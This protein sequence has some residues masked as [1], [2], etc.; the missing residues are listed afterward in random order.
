M[1]SYFIIVTCRNSENSIE[2]ALISL[3]NQS[4]KPEYVIVVDDGSTD[5]TP[6]ILM[7]IKAEWS[8]SALHIITNP[9]LGYNIAR[10]VSN[11]NNAI[12]YM[13]EMK[14]KATDYHMI[15]TDDTVY[16]EQYAEKLVRYMGEDQAIA[17][18]SGDYGEGMA[19]TPHG[20]GRVVRNSFFFQKYGLYPEKMGYESVVLYAAALHNYTYRVFFDARFEH[21][22]KLGTNHHFYEFGASM[23]SLG[24][25]PLFVLGRF[26]IYFIS[27]KPIGRIGALYML[28]HYLHFKPKKD[29]YGSLHDYYIRDFIRQT[30]RNRI[31]QFLKF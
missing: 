3:R 9:D 16:E 23:R 1:S 14:L 30:Q 2:Q 27:G 8:G 24:Y 10:V 25:H 19:K 31:K 5:K 13:H 17:I 18:S 29:G 21:L 4:L 6:E 15:T 22:R 12:K 26:C 7:R 28:Y 20:A 11:W